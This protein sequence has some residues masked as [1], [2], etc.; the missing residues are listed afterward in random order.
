MKLET[1]KDIEE[2]DR[3]PVK[4]VSQRG[5]EIIDYLIKESKLKAKAIKWAQGMTGKARKDWLEFFNIIE[6]DLIKEDKK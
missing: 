2:E 3:T 5:T 6:E 1:L 4:L